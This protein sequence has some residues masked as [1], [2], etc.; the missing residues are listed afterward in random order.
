MIISV[1]GATALL[2][3]CILKVF[4]TREAVEHQDG[5][6]KETFDS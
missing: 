2:L 5:L 1:G 6:E 4:T 3:W